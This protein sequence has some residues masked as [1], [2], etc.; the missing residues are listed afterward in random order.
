MGWRWGVYIK[1]KNMV[2][3]EEEEEEEEEE[4]TIGS[5]TGKVA[6]KIQEE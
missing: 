3:V 2:E 1:H 6:R 4:E 5:R